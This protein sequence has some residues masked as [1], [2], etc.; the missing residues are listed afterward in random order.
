MKDRSVGNGEPQTDREA[1]TV[2]PASMK[3]RSV[4]NGERQ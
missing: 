2:P 4:G 1:A 3:G